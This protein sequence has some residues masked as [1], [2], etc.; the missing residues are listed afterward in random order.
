MR[1]RWIMAGAGGAI[2]VALTLG[3]LAGTRTHGAK[4]S[5]VPPPLPLTAPTGSAK[6]AHPAT[7]PAKP[8]PASVAATDT[9]SSDST[10][11]ALLATADQAVTHEQWL[12]ARRTYQQ[13]L[14]EHPTS[15]EAIQAQQRLGEIN[16]RLLLSPSSAPDAPFYQESMVELGDTLGKIARQHH[17][18]VELLRVI[19]HIPHDKIL[20][21]RPLRVPRVTFS[22]IVDKSQNT[23]TLKANEEV[24]KVYT[25][26]TGKEDQTPVGTFTI[27]NRLVDPP[28]YTA[29][30]VIPP[31]SPEN[32]LGTRWMGFSKPSYGI[33]GTTDASTIGQSVTAGCVR[34][35]NDEVEELYTFLP[36]GTDVT[37]VD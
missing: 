9:A 12:E 26:S 19:N 13:I 37:I 2:V 36:I 23:L 18:T 25:V 35:R 17:T 10:A 15:P 22:V 31:G 4:P 16:I 14:Q 21:G 20:V 27:V 29:R 28:W 8:A 11:R 5:I 6:S 24:I 7:V 34:M 33:H 30:G 32:I 3:F 1:E